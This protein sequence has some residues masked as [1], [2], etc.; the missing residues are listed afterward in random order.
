L[1][2]VAQRGAK[3]R[4]VEPLDHVR[5]DDGQRYCPETPRDEL[6]VRGIVVVD[7]PRGELVTLS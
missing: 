3:R 1:R 5:P 6:V 2:F 7:V 4:L